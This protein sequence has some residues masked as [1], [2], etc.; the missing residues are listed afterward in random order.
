MDIAKLN[1]AK[2]D[3]PAARA[4]ALEAVKLNPLLDK[5]AWK[6]IGNIYMG[7]FNDC[8]KKQSQIDDRA[9]FM[10]AYDAYAKAGD[11]AGMAQASAQFPTVSDVFTENK[12][13][14]ESVTLGCWIQVTTT[15]R[16]R[17]SE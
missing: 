17:P 11:N 15:I 3:K 12:K 16:S 14:G 10:A 1:L 2:G 5:E 7:S 4:A 9:V 8:A 13:E 6:F